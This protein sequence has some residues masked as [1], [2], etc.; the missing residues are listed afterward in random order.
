MSSIV[1]VKS[2]SGAIYCYE[3]IPRWIPELGQS[4]PIKRYLGRLNPET[5]KIE[6]T[7]RQKKAE[8]SQK[9]H[10]AREDDELVRIKEENK[11]LW[12]EN[13]SLKK[14]LDRLNSRISKYEE[15][16]PPI[17]SQLKQLK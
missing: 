9:A 7:T 14:D 4:R 10:S 11:S 13:K 3:S 12:A 2:K 1:K 15:I 5:G 8:S 6:P 16:I 17:I